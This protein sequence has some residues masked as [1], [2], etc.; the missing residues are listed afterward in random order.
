M[1]YEMSDAEIIA[2]KQRKIESLQ[3]ELDELAKLHISDLARVSKRNEHL[4]SQIESL[5]NKWASREL[6]Q[7]DS[8]A[9]EASNEK[10]RGALEKLA[11][12]KM[13]ELIDKLLT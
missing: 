3:Q 11:A 12:I 13:H 6:S 8:D 10:L 1:M 7:Q 4:Q 5:Q 9:L 2:S